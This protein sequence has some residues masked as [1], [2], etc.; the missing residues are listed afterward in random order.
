ML[1]ITRSYLCQQHCNAISCRS[2]NIRYRIKRLQRNRSG[3]QA[4]EVQTD[5]RSISVVRG[6]KETT[7]IRILQMMFSAITYGA[8][9]PAC[10][11]LM[12]ILTLCRTILYHTFVD[13]NTV[14][15]HIIPC[16]TIL[17][18]LTYHTIP[19]GSLCLGGLLAPT[20]MLLTLCSDGQAARLQFQVQDRSR[21]RL[22]ADCLG[23]YC[24]GLNN[25]QYIPILWLHILII[26]S[27]S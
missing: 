3:F 23:H 26:A 17:T 5:S 24:R 20:G 16:H 19:K 12:L 18:Y 9:E 7:D 25:Y 10:R 6:P 13:T 11:I 15:C 1:V 14:P 2:C 27:V 22:H 21:S 4:R 8:F